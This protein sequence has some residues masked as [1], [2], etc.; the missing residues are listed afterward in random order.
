M[1]LEK[2]LAV[3]CLQQVDSQEM[4]TKLERLLSIPMEDQQ[5]RTLF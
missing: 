1:S 2:D 5:N 3:I 4:L